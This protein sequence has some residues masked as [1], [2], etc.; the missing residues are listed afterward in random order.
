[1]V[2]IK[3]SRQRVDSTLDFSQAE[4]KAP[5]KT[6]EKKIKNS[7]RSI[8][9][10]T[11]SQSVKNTRH[12][13]WFVAIVPLVFLF[14]ALSYMFA[15]AMVTVN[16]KIQDIVLKENLS[17]SKDA[18]GD[19]LP[20]DLVII[21][22]EETKI[23]QATEEKDVFQKAE[24]SVVIYNT[25]SS[26]SQ[27]LS[28]DTRLEGSNGKIYKTKKQVN[29][30]GV[31]GNIPG[32]VEVGIYGSEAG[33][34][35]NSAPLDFKIFGFKGTPKYS[36]F[37]ARSNVE[38]TKTKG[39]ITGG[40]KG[41]SLVIS[42]SQ[43]TSTVNEMK[44]ALSIKLFK[45]AIDQIPSDF[46][47]FKNGFYFN[48]DDVDGVK[49]IPEKDNDLSVRVSGT[50]YGF[51]FNESKLTQKLAKNKIG[52]YNDSS[53]YI[54]NLRDLNFSILDKDINSATDIKSIDFSLSGSGKFVWKLDVDKFTNDL[55]GKSKKDIKQ[56]MAGYP[57]IDSVDLVV[58]PF[59]KMSIPDKAK[60]IKVTIN[61]PI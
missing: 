17:A 29:V 2:K 35:Y 34:E 37:Y 44:T 4:P 11:I 47:L 54:S 16:P 5:E 6:L 30:P 8:T 13:L 57:N 41:K 1:M 56:I 28:I 25:F 20:L 39:A 19:V 36:K 46:V 26:A 21:S 50:L 7:T 31:K 48:V 61:Y 9:R 60:N 3:K 27:L 10:N 24:G 40:F 49:Y 43:K 55:L 12:Y 18:T 14:F 59:W 22:G 38:D 15:K 32:S 45:K 58:S 51:L 23:V 33:E 53:I 52:N 42:E